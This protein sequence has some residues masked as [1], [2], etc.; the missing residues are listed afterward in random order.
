MTQTN[1]EFS[2]ADIQANLQLIGSTLAMAFHNADA[3]ASETKQALLLSSAKAHASNVE[4]TKAILEGYANKFVALGYSDGIVRTRKSEAN[5][6]FKACSMKEVTQ[7]NI[8]AL[9]SFEGD[10]HQF[11]SKARELCNAGE[12]KKEVKISNRKPKLTD[13]QEAFISEKMKSATI[14]Q[15]TDFIET[16]TKELNKPHDKE[17]A[18]LAEKNQLALIVSICKQMAKNDTTDKIIL[19]CV[20]SVMELIKPV[21]AKL[22]IVEAQANTTAYDLKEAQA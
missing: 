6:V 14:Y 1:K 4:G 8:K 16:A 5:Q 12:A 7:D 13:T 21:L 2:P 22:D 11:I 19:D 20:T 9:E 18:V 15:L 10:Y 3:Q 17:S